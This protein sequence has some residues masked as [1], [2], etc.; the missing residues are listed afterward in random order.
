MCRSI[1]VNF[2]YSTFFNLILKTKQS[3]TEFNR[4]RQGHGYFT[5]RLNRFSLRFDIQGV[6]G[7]S[8]GL[9]LLGSILARCLCGADGGICNSVPA[10]HNKHFGSSHYDID[11][12]SMTQRKRT[13]GFV[14]SIRVNKDACMALRRDS[15]RRVYPASFL[16]PNSCQCPEKA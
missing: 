1:I 4:V 14:R 2:S 5:G 16:V 3:T 7:W 6:G 11:F 13:T 12:E 9:E 8:T 10:L 15:S